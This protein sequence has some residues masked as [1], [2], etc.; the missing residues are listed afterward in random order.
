MTIGTFEVLIIFGD[1]QNKNN[2][3]S[4]TCP[5][6]IEESTFE[7]L[8]EIITMIFP[9][10]KICPCFK[11]EIQRNNTFNR[12]ENHEKIKDYITNSGITI[13]IYQEDNKNCDYKSYY[14]KSKKEI[15]DKLLQCVNNN[16]KNKLKEEN[17]ILKPV[18]NKDIDHIN[19][20]R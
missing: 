3:N 18:N 7:Y 19:E 10:K 14:Q 9:E 6:N 15:I 17:Q 13:K 4:F 11:Y 1:K 20:I 2:Q 12:I 16:N 8:F 5:Y